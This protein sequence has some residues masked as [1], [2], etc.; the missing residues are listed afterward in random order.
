MPGDKP[1]RRRKRG[2]SKG[3]VAR[4]VLGV[5]AGWIALSVVVF[6]IS[7]QIQQGA[8]SGDANQLLGGAGPP[9]FSANNI[10]VLG[11]DQRTKGTAEPGAQTSGGRSDSIMLMRIGGGAN[12]RLSIARDTVV[13]I[14]G[15]G[16]Q[17]IN[18][19]FAIGGTALAIRTVEAYTGIDVNHVVV[20][21]FDDFPDLIDA[22]GGI[23][24]QGGCVISFINGGFKNGG[25][26]LRLK[27]GKTHITGHQAL[28]LARTRKNRCAKN[29]NDLT[30]AKRQ[31]KIFTAM[32]RRL[33]SP[34]AFIR[35]PFISWQA[36]K[37]LRS[38]MSGP[39]LLGVFS[40]LAF[41]G[42]PKTSVLGSLSGNV[43]DAAKRAAVT[44]FLDG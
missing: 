15:A 21:S 31:Q 20:V 36:P 10:L 28:A 38:D 35:L 23:T 9:P 30:R 44:R 33:L 39:T 6:L 14:P 7:A 18:A 17:K 11:S 12:S 13:D 29:E 2:W 43:P 8:I 37:A 27:A 25:Y 40:A 41:S 26:T 34:G 22:M 16:R 19:A 24:Y 4:W 5:L 1:R 32:K 3:R 42:T